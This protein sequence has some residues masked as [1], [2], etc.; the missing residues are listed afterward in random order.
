MALATSLPPG[1]G[2]GSTTPAGRVRANGP[3]LHP[4]LCALVPAASCVAHV[5][6][7]ASGGLWIAGGLATMSVV[8]GFLYAQVFGIHREQIL[9]HITAGF[10]LWYLI[11]AVLNQSVHAFVW[12]RAA[13][14]H[15]ASPF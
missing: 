13:I 10:L 9:P 2:R 14:L 15:S 3:V 7:A 12:G 1:Q 5:W 6:L 11:S 8:M 4:R